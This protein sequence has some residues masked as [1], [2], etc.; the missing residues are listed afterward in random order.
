MEASA[1]GKCEYGVK[2]M[3]E[4]LDVFGLLHFTMLRPFS[5]GARFEIYEPFISLIFKVWGGGPL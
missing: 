4:V 5:P 3:S 1:A 2:E